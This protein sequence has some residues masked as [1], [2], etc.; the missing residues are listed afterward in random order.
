MTAP[1]PPPPDASVPSE[2]TRLSRYFDEQLV[3]LFDSYKAFSH[4]LDDVGEALVA[5]GALIYIGRFPYVHKQRFWAAFLAAQRALRV[6][7][8]QAA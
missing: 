1:T 3:E 6:E 4:H 5:D 8:L 2:F 7:R